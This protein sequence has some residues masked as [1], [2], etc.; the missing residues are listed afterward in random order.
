MKGRGGAGRREGVVAMMK[1]MS[2]ILKFVWGICVEIGKGRMREKMN[3][4]IIG[5][6]GIFLATEGVT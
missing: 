2:F 6:M 5:K 4:R 1:K 3:K